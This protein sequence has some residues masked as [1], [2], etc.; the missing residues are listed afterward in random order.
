MRLFVGVII[1][2][3]WNS[4]RKFIFHRF[5]KILVYIFYINK[6]DGKNNK[7]YYTGVAIFS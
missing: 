7:N 3:I 6:R 5:M 2:D 1:Y 4:T